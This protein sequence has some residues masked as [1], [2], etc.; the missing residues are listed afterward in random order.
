[1]RIDPRG[2][3]IK[4]TK[5]IG[6]FSRIVAHVCVKIRTLMLFRIL[7]WISAEPSPQI[8]IVSA[9]N[10]QIEIA[11]GVAV[12]TGKIHVGG[13]VPTMVVERP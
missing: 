6:L 8:R 4:Q 12:E 1:M 9:V 13:L 10:C 5:S 2:F 11:L 3:A 7:E